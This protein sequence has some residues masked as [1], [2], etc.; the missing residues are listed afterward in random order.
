MKDWFWFLFYSITGGRPMNLLQYG[1]YD[2]VAG[3]PVYY[4]KDA[5]GRQWMAFGAWSLFRVELE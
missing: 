2:S 3:Q 1:F 5:F 4:W